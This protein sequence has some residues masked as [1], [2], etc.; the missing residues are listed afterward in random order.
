MKPSIKILHTADWHIGLSSWKTQ[1]EVERLEEQ[2]ECLEEMLTVAK[3]ERVDLVI[4]AGDLFHH[5]H[6]PPRE[7]IRL[8][9]ETILAFAEIAPFVWVMGNHDWYAAEPLRGFFPERVLVIK[10]FAAR[11]L[12]ALQVSIFPLPYLSLARFLGRGP[13]SESQE[14]VKENILAHVKN[15]QENRRPFFWNILVAH[16]TIEDLALRYLEANAN[17]EIFLKKGDLPSFF[18]YGAFGHL[19]DM[20]P[21]REPFPIQ[22]PSSLV[23]DSFTQAGKKGGGF[24][25]VELCEGERAKV[26]PYFL[27]SSRLLSFDLEEKTE[28]N[29]VQAMIE[30][31]LGARRNYVRLRI[32]EEVMDAGWFRSL[33]D[34]QGENWKVVMVEMIP[35]ERES[36]FPEESTV[37]VDTIPELFSRFCR[38]NRFPE[39]LIR[40]FE[41]YYRRALEEETLG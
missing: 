14:S 5:S 13:G 12:D 29:L 7:A 31:N 28:M 17:R 23:P 27:E 25:I 36:S 1:K 41:F 20:I 32:R 10:D 38:E 30:K 6:N 3:R 11:H 4:H 24:V 15:W 22:Y 19:H 26:T 33:K 18:H 21:L 8:A 9:T 39:T 16:V 37:E 40:L 2:Q 35:R 34:L